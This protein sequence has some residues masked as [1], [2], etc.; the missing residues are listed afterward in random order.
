MKKT[1]KKTLKKVSNILKDNFSKIL[2]KIIT[3]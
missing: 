3:L 1:N 2:K